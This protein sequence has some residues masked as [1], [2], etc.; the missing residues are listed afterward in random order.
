MRAQT[1]ALLPLVSASLVLVFRLFVL[2]RMLWS[3]PLNHGPGYFFGVQVPPGFYEGPGIRWLK[4]YRILLLAQHLFLV[5]AFMVPVAL[6]RW[7]DLPVMAPV[8]VI[9]FFSIFGG[10]WLWA[11]R[12]L[13]ANPP[14]LSSVAVP[15]GV[16][17]LADY[18]SWPLEAMIVAFLAFS[19]LLLSTQGDAHF[20]WQWPVLISYAVMGMLPCK[21]ILARNSF[22][23]PPERTEEHQR[24]QEAYRR[25]S[26]R[27]IESMRWFLVAILAAYA[28][29]H[30]SPAAKAMVWLEWSFLGSAAALYLVMTGILFHGWRATARMGRD[31]RP[32]G[33]WA[34]PFQPARVMLRGGL[35]WSILYCSGLVA[36]LVFFQR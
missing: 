32:V 16:R 3:Y 18:I 8:D 22:P 11:R 15:L 5:S 29:R 25:Y 28:V 33:S 26:L 1:N 34:G 24:W 27:V 13:G 31:L 12:S 4:R 20:R 36:L 2:V 7:N 10:F 30:G 9:T 21:I 23:L 19:W 35:T 14:R 6:R 17:R